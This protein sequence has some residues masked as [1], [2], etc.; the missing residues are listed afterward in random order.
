MPP[1]AT[2]L[3]EICHQKF[4][5]RS[6]P[7]HQKSC[8]KKREESTSFCPVCDQLVSNDEYQKHYGECKII[9]AGLLKKKKDMAAAAAKKKG[10]ADPTS[11]GNAPAARSKI[12]ESVLRRL[13]AHA[14]GQSTDSPEQVLMKRLG[15]PCHS[16][17]TATAV[18]ACMGCH[19]VYCK[20]C[21]DMIHE[22]NTALSEHKPVLREELA[23]AAA[24]AAAAA[25][26]VDLREPCAQCGRSFAVDRLAKHNLVCTKIAS[27]KPRK[28]FKSGAETRVAGTDFSKFFNP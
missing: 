13:E 5:V 21:C 20:S 9:N 25:A 2:V 8:V 22:V 1:P 15:G 17:G 19:T 16:C 14:G 4:S 7:L 23:R 18:A 6:L 24:A 28:A 27:A 12:P 3:C 10:P 11:T 26:A